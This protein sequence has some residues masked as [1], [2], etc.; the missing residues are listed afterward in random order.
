MNLEGFT[1]KIIGTRF[2]K[3]D[4]HNA[5]QIPIYSNA[6][7][8]FD[9]A[10]TMED[11]FTG[12]KPAHMYSRITNPT[13][14]HLE[15]LIKI[16]TNAQG[17]TALSSGMAAISNTFLS[18]V[19]QGENIITSRHLFGNTYSLF[20]K[21]LRSFGIDVRFADL[22]NKEEIEKL[23]DSNT[24][25]LFFETITNPQMEV[26]DISVLAD[27][28]YKHRLLLIADSTLTPP[29][30]FNAKNHGINIELIS[31]T[32]IISGGA[33]SV[34]G[35]IIDYGNFDWSKNKK[36]A[37]LTTQFGTFAFQ[38][39]LRKEI[40]RNIGACLSPFNAYLQSVGIE[41]LELR[42]N[43]AAENTLGVAHFLD[44]ISLVKK[45]NYPGIESSPYYSISKKQFGS[46]PG[47]ILTF[48]LESKEQC[49]SFINKLQLIRRATNLQDNRSLIIHPASTI[50]GDY[51][52]EQKSLMHISENALRLSLGIEDI[53]DIINDIKQ[54]I[55]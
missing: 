22:T 15:N 7:F 44:K 50:F 48:E 30:I 4:A 21:T 32:K 49:F 52:A 17:V 43:K 23:I 8:E 3:E 40:F 16:V 31:S 47:S 51:S 42:F 38:Y 27:I 24:R 26:V 18:I 6:A 34:G 20:D 12:K 14:E 1:S 2:L 9:D 35:L 36:L 37:E 25:V 46:L 13:V 11:A 41:T 5:L 33:T 55:K 29:I 10:E 45:V 54:A 28:A 19:S 53:E 39:K